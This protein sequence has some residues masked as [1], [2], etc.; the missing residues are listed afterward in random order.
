M[1]DGDGAALADELG[2]ADELAAAGLCELPFAARVTGPQPAT[3]SA[4]A[5]I[6]TD[7]R[8]DRPRIAVLRSNQDIS[9]PDAS[10]RV[11]L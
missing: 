11:P 8:D 5:S 1:A 3:A 9:S 4:A 7:A 2:F 10:M 6:R